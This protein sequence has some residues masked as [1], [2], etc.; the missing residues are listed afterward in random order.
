MSDAGDTA[1]VVRALIDFV[2]SRHLATADLPTIVVKVETQNALENLPAILDCL[3][4]A[5]PNIALEV[6]RGDLA[7]EVGLDKLGA[8]QERC[9]ALA[10]ARHLPIGVAT[11]VLASMR[12]QPV[13][14]RA[15]VSD[16]HHLL[17]AGASFFV[18]TEETANE[19]CHPAA[20]ISALAALVRTT[21]PRARLFCLAGTSGVG[22]STI[23][24]AL[25]QSFPGQ[26]AF[27]R[28]VTTRASRYHED[29]EVISQPPAHFADQARRGRL[30]ALYCA[31]CH[32]YG[33]SL[34]ELERL[35][36]QPGQRWIGCLT[37][38]AA[39]ALRD[40][41]YDITVIYLTV[42]RR[43]VLLERLRDRGYS[44]EEI[45]MR[46]HEHDDADAQ[47]AAL[48]A[49]H[50]LHTDELTVAES[51]AAVASILE[52]PALTV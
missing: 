49:D 43:G 39:L 1:A 48:C 14:T 37:A 42:R 16:V 6:A 45:A 38:S 30:T 44:D 32:S 3:S 4:G 41:G 35:L 33:L 2:R 18:L 8:A 22:K 51:V 15:E 12:T 36:S 50:V 20:A 34:D 7:L 52:L 40:H 5:A 31:N 24:S 46:L 9:F 10:R 19:A 23:R 28:R 11:G 29:G 47:W 17:R 21:Q 25:L 13:P 26:L 27:L